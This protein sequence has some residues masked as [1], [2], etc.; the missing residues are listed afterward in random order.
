MPILGDEDDL[1]GDDEFEPELFEQELIDGREEEVL[2]S[3]VEL[4]AHLLAED[5]GNQEEWDG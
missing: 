5:H 4:L 1:F 2:D 3:D